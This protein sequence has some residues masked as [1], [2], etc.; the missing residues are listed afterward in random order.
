MNNKQEEAIKECIELKKL[1]QKILKEFKV[2]VDDSKTLIHHY[3]VE[4]EIDDLI[5]EEA[6]WTL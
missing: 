3:R 4:D 2:T 1:N 5:N 6:G